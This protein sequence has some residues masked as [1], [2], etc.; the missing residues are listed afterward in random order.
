[1]QSGCGC[2]EPDGSIC[3]IAFHA[4]K[5]VVL[6]S[7]TAT[8]LSVK[9]VDNVVSASVNSRMP[10]GIISNGWYIEEGVTL[11]SRSSVV[12]RLVEITDERRNKIYHSFHLLL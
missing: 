11:R 1:M 3:L 8:Q 9:A 7:S 10:Y 4:D 12:F 5:P 2:S 6:A